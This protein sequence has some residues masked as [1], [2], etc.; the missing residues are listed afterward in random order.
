MT[1][2]EDY[3][4]VTRLRDRFRH[5][6]KEEGKRHVEAVAANHIE[7]AQECAVSRSCYIQAAMECNLEL[8]RLNDKDQATANPKH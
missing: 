7:A 1:S 6:Y 8:D 2:Q 4:A 3:A 5:L